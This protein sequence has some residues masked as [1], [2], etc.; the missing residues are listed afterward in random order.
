MIRPVDPGR[1]AA[2]CADILAPYA[3]GPETFLDGAP[4]VAEMRTAIGRT[5]ATHPWLVA[6]RDGLVVG[7]AYAG[8]HRTRPAY[9][10]AA[11]VSVY[12]D[13]ACQRQGVGRSLYEEL[14]VQL[15]LQR[16]HVA[17]AGISLPNPGSIALHE[18]VGFTGGSLP[19]HRLEGR[20]VAVGR[21][22]AAH[23]RQWFRPGRRAHPAGRA[24]SSPVAVSRR[25]ALP[26]WRSWR[27]TRRVSRQVRHLGKS[28]RAQVRE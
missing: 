24:G 25:P 18:A 20:G 11:E 19:G 2:R 27:R 3:D 17:L 16:L 22:V 21:L 8:P 7:Y 9:R 10:W 6:E 5:T 26:R 1:D 15:R 28:G 12:V 14:L 23:P 13:R 4:S